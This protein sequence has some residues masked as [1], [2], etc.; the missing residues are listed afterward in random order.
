MSLLFIVESEGSEDEI[1]M[2]PC[3]S[4]EPEAKHPRLSA[5]TETGQQSTA[6]FRPG[7]LSGIQILER[8][9]PFQKR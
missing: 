8:I 7:R 4:P 2:S 3:S 6:G 5:P 1:D 9:F